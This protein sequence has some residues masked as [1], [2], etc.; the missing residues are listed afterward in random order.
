MATSLNILLSKLNLKNFDRSLYCEMNFK[1]IFF[2][3]LISSLTSQSYG[4]NWEFQVEGGLLQ[5]SLF[6]VQGF[7]QNNATEGWGSIDPTARFELW[8]KNPEGWNFGTVLQPLYVR[9]EDVFQSQLNAEGKVF[10][11]GQGGVIDFQFHS[12]RES[13]NYPLIGNDLAPFY[14]RGGLSLIGRYAQ[15]DIRGSGNEYRGTNFIVLPLLNF[16]TKLQ[17]SEQ[18]ALLFS[19]DFVPGIKGDLL[20]N[21]LYDLLFSVKYFTAQRDSFDMGVRLFFGGYDP[22]KVDFFANR[23]FQAAYVLRFNF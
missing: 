1:K 2:V 18:L 4:R 21:S 9:F 6:D 12:I 13:F 8:S 5:T 15:I 23:I 16:E 10:N 11:A 22:E 20:T 3:F 17:L 19:G 14:L 7:G